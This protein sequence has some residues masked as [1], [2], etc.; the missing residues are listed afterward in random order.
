[1]SRAK[2]PQT[3]TAEEANK[4]SIW[5]LSANASAETVLDWDFKTELLAEAVKQVL[6]AGDAIMFGTRYDGG[7]ISVIIMS[8]EERTRRWCD[9]AIA[10][11]DVLGL[12]V[13]QGKKA[14]R[15]ELRA[16]GD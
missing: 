4:R 13:A 10:F 16:V 6:S 5:N 1:M 2:R 12:I 8:G 3:Y 11:E 15:V 14:G 9:D 7:A